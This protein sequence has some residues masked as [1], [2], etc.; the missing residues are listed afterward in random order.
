MSDE[1]DKHHAVKNRDTEQSD[2]S[3]SSGNANYAVGS[4][5]VL[6]NSKNKIDIQNLSGG[7]IGPYLQHISINLYID[8][9]L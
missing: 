3:N 5:T 9:E 4:A 7:S 1:I 6:S 8:A 2:E